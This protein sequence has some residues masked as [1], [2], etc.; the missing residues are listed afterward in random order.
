MCDN[1]NNTFQYW[2]SSNTSTF[3]L[4]VCALVKD[5]ERCVSM[6][7][8][9]PSAHLALVT[10]PVTCSWFCSIPAP[11][12]EEWLSAAAAAP[13]TPGNVGARFFALGW[14]WPPEK[15]CYF[16]HLYLQ[17]YVFKED[18]WRQWQLHPDIYVRISPETLIHVQFSLTSIAITVGYNT[19]SFLTK[20]QLLVWPKA[21]SFW[22]IT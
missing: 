9:V 1:N 17:N 20:Q 12:S 18:E 13:R 21:V 5:G 3:F 2:H 15:H 22:W 4:C 8:H 11:I 10:A 6:Y 7:F 14:R 19:G 16:L